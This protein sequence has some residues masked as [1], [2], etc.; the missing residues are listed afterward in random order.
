MPVKLSRFFVVMMFILSVGILGTACASDPDPISTT[1]SPTTARQAVETQQPTEATPLFK[2]TSL[3]FSDLAGTDS[4]GSINSIAATELG[5]YAI[6]DVLR[7]GNQHELYL[8]YVNREGFE[9]LRKDLTEILSSVFDLYDAPTIAVSGADQLYMYAKHKTDFSFIFQ[10]LDKAGNLVGNPILLEDLSL[11]DPVTETALYE[12][13]NLDKDN[14]VLAFGYASI[15]KQRTGVLDVYSATGEFQY[16]CI[17]NFGKNVDESSRWKFLNV[18]FTDKNTAYIAAHYPEGHVM[19]PINHS[20]ESLDA[21]IP[22]WRNILGVQYINGNI[23]FANNNGL[24]LLDING[25]T[26]NELFRW[27][28]LNLPFTIADAKINIVSENCIVVTTVDNEYYLLT[29]GAII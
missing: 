24:Y 1:R 21:P 28:K 13:F 12:S 18:I 23:Y 15:N 9:I 7:E 2:V 19:L 17:D 20:T 4:T 22:F 8:T 10:L 27:G 26:Q 11:L 14:Y 16:R 6:M 3:S 29:R 25:Y 5:A